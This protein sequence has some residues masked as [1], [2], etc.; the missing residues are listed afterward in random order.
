M[1]VS[2]AIVTQYYTNVIRVAPTAAQVTFYSNAADAATLLTTLENQATVQ[3]NPIIRLYQGAFNR[4]PDPVGLNGWVAQYV[5]GPTGTG[6]ATLNSIA[7]GFVGSAEFASLYGV[8]PIATV[9]SQTAM[10]SNLYTNVLNRPAGQV[11]VNL[12]LTEIARQ[13]SLGYS[14]TQIATNVLLGFTNSPEFITSSAPSIQAFQSSSALNTET[15]TG[16]LWA[17]GAGTTYT[18][19]TDINTF[20]PGSNA[21]VDGTQTTFQAAD[22][23]VASGTNNKLSL[24][25]N[26]TA[27]WTLPAATVSGLQT[28]ALR[29]IN[30]TAATAAVAQVSTLTYSDYTFAAAGTVTVAN[31]ATAAVVVVLDASITGANLAVSVASGINAAAG[32]LYVATVSGNTVTLTAKTAGAV[33]APTSVTV[34]GVAS[35]GAVGSVASITAGAAAVA[36]TGAVDTL[37]ADNFIGMTTF[38]SDRSTSAVTINDVNNGMQITMNG[39]TSTV[40][41]GALTAVFDAGVSAITFNATNGTGTSTTRGAVALTS[42]A[43]TDL[44]TATINSTGGTNR[45]GVITLNGQATA[46]NVNATTA[47]DITSIAVGTNV[48]AQS[49]IVSGAAANRAATG[50]A[51]PTASVVLGLLDSDIDVVNASGLTAGGVSLTINDTAAVITGGTGTDFITTAAGAQLGTVTA[52]AGTDVLIQANTNAIATLTAGNLFSGFEI[53]Q[54]NDGVALDMDLLATNNT[55]GAI[56]LNNAGGGNAITD[57][58]AIQAANITVLAANGATTFALKTATGTADVMN[59]LVSD[60]D[61]TSGEANTVAGDWTIANVETINIT[62]FDNMTLAATNN[63]T[64]VNSIIVSGPGAVSITTGAMAATSGMA[65]DY[66]GITATTAT[67]NFAAATTQPITFVGSAGADLV[68]DSVIGGNVLN[69]GAG[70]DVITLTNKG[71]GTGGDV[72]TAGAAG[73][74]IAA[75]A[76][77]G[78]A[79]F[80]KFTLKFA[81]GDSVITSSVVGTGFDAGTM[82]SVTGLDLANAAA[83]G[84]G[85][86]VTFDTAQSATAVTFSA[87]AVTFGTTA[88]T[89]AF[90]FYVYNTGVGGVSYI[91][92]DTDG[93]KII[94]NGEFGVQIVGVAATDTTAT[95]F[96]VT[97]GNLVLTTVAG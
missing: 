73:D 11:E 23:I 16:S 17:Q 4:V 79:V 36:S 66:S 25:D 95:E 44:T 49:I 93:D 12:W 58:S 47:L 69:T 53:Y 56:R 59:I 43:V 78:N 74:T 65:F 46:I 48:A 55:I 1:A 9:Q 10:V 84:A 68:T 42:A 41:N 52:G 24:I 82:D 8:N 96:A 91:Y 28:V 40:G 50:T 62:A 7:T 2:S 77:L 94:E 81:N 6:T 27:A 31:V 26:G 60:L 86:V 76:A 88:V 37:D 51:A 33:T 85:N 35:V 18:L 89:N 71:S 39:A 32:S 70:Q 20:T 75:G 30:G 22:S 19:T 13:Q 80:E 90:D 38:I 29:N 92:Q 83:A 97:T 45:V 15:Y 34:P 87:T 63:I 64:G 57:M 21:V 72:I 3:V 67:L 61:L 54:A 14:N 5:S